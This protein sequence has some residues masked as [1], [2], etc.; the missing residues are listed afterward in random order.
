MESLL[1]S[2]CVT[3][4]RA[5]YGHHIVA[6]LPLKLG[7][8]ILRSEPPV[9]RVPARERREQLCAH[10]LAPTDEAEGSTHCEQCSSSFCSAAC[11]ASETHQLECEC[12]S[13]LNEYSDVHWSDLRLALRLLSLPQCPGTVSEEVADLESH[14]EDALCVQAA[15]SAADTL[16]PWLSTRSIDRDQLELAVRVVR[17]NCFSIIDSAT[18]EKIGTGLFREASRFNH[19]CNPTCCPVF[20]PDGSMSLRLVSPLAAGEEIT[21]TYC[22]PWQAR[23]LRRVDLRQRFHFDCTCVRCETGQTCEPLNS[24]LCPSCEGNL[25]LGATTCPGC[26]VATD[27]LRHIETMKC[28]EKELNAVEAD[29][30]NPLQAATQAYTAAEAQLNACHAALLGARE[31]LAVANAYREQWVAAADLLLHNLRCKERVSPAL[32][33]RIEVAGQWQNLAEFVAHAAPEEFEAE[34]ST[35]I[36]LREPQQTGGVAQRAIVKNA[37]LK[38]INI[39]SISR[40]STHPMCLNLAKRLVALTRALK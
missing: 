14:L 6:D 7:T 35:L 31:R 22:D 36:G 29:N 34:S 37:L 19:S 38:A 16:A 32:S 17:C 9:A 27:T 12:L 18:G 26:G 10:C 28:L 23:Q 15:Q 13:H 8:V 33:N 4:F 2:A 3:A 30:S 39:V 40:G 25:N 24:L 11:A 5:D 1:H 21:I 20:A